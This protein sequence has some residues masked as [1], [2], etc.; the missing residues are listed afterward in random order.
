MRVASAF[1]LLIVRCSN[2]LFGRIGCLS[3]FVQ[4]MP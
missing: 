2:S 1:E 3:A 4:L